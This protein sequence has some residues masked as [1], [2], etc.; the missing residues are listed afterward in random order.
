MPVAACPDCEADVQLDADIR[1]T[2]IVE[3]GECRSE[4]EVVTVE[5][6]SLSQA[7]EVEEDWGE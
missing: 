3:C 2:E 6:A 1:V 7:P 4:L 5:P